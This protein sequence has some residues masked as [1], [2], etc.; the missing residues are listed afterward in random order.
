[1]ECQHLETQQPIE[2]VKLLHHERLSNK[3]HSEAFMLEMRYSGPTNHGNP[4]NVF[5]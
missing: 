1:M 5:N 3:T 4:D 2:V